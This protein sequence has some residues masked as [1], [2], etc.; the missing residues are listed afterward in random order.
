VLP[1]ILADVRH[2]LKEAQ[3]AIP[4]VE[5]RRQAEESPDPVSFVAAVDRRG[6]SVI[7]EAK[8][9]SPSRGVLLDPYDPVELARAYKRGGARALSVL[10]ERDHFAG[11]GADLQA[12]ARETDLPVL[13]K[14]FLV[15][16]YQC[17]EARAWGASAALLIVAV[18]EKGALADLHAL[19][20]ELQVTPLVEVHTEAEAERALNA[21]VEVIGVNNRDLSTFRTDLSVTERV[22]AMLP[23]G[24]RV[25]SESGIA[26]REDVLRV[27]RVG[28]S[29]VLVGEALVTAPDPVGCLAELTGTEETA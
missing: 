9:A 26:S 7:A 21:G 1:A 10:T 17:W 15:D 8:R 11:S 28:A 5:V 23:E 3:R 14:D 19:L 18:L 6:T 27:E 13:R 22:G 24:V 4:A 29:A 2:R 12:V 20:T 16:A 25:V